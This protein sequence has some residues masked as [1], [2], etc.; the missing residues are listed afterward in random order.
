MKIYDGLE[1]IVPPFDRATVAVGTF[2]GV[3]IGHQA[4]LRTAVRDARFFVR[5]ALVFTFD[6]HPQELLAPEYAPAYITTPE[7][8]NRLIAETGADGLIIARFDTALSQLSPDA[9]MQTILKDEL[10]AEAIVVGSNFG[11]GRNRAGNVT[12]LEQA[13]E[14]F[15]FTLHAI[16]PVLLDGSPASS[17]RVRELLRTGD[18]AA[19]ERVLGHAYWLAGTVVEGQKPGVHSVIPPPILP[20]DAGRSFLLMASMFAVRALLDDGRE[21]GGA[22]SIGNRPTIPGAGRSIETFL[23]DFDEDIYGRGMELRFVLYLRPEATFD[24]LAALKVQM[25]QDV[26][27]ARAAL[28]SLRNARGSEGCL[29]NSRNISFLP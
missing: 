15:L 14:R 28:L 2:D 21:I 8:R 17:T 3:H 18:I 19:A 25:A 13:Q 16:E 12:Y 9:F 23:F 29:R 6:R 5:P 4:L 11:F 7:Q 22:C 1:T 24:S 10:G 26:E 20:C 27:D